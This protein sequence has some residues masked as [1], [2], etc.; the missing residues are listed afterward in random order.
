MHSPHGTTAAASN[1]RARTMTRFLHVSNG[2]S[3]SPPLL[4]R[5]GEGDLRDVV[6]LTDEG[7]DV[8]AGRR[9]RLALCGFDRWFGGVH[10][11]ADKN[12]WRW[13]DRRQEVV[14]E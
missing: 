10:V 14:R 7:R 13:D 8:L 3:T 2:T 9:D 1:S 5:T 11:Q 6:S 4:V 12:L